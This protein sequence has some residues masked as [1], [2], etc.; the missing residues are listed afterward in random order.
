MAEHKTQFVGSWDHGLDDKGRMVLPAKVRVQLGETGVLGMLDRCLGLWTQEGFETVADNMRARVD[1]GLLEMDSLRLFM[2]NA[3][4]V[5]PDG[6][7]RIVVPAPLRTYA[8]IGREAV[9]V[10][11]H[12]R[13]EIWDAGRW[14]ELTRTQNENLAEAISGLRI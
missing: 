9:I 14:N 10:G 1:E 5:S 13:A 8:G 4:H 2:A 12:D 7:G 6:Q 3:A 11:N